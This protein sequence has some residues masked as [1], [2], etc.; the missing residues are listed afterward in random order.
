MLKGLV[1]EKPGSAGQSIVVSWDRQDLAKGG[2]PQRNPRS[3][4][5]PARRGSPAGRKRSSVALDAV[6]HHMLTMLCPEQ[7]LALR[8]CVAS[9][10]AKTRVSDD[11]MRQPLPPRSCQGLELSRHEW[12][13]GFGVFGQKHAFCKACKTAGMPSRKTNVS[14]GERL[15]LLFESPRCSNETRKA[16]RL[17]RRVQKFGSA[18]MCPLDCTRKAVNTSSLGSGLSCPKKNHDNSE[19]CWG[20]SASSSSENQIVSLEQILVGRHETA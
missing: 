2:S 5:P 15:P 19:K 20:P 9:L 17:Q 4:E 1:Q 6:A 14:T 13:W 16:V 12:S 8:F 10:A 18:E 3:A 7:H 11:A